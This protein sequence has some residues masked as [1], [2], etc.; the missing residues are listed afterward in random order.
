MI[1]LEF[2]DLNDI[3]VFLIAVG[4]A[5]LVIIIGDVLKRKAHLDTRF[6]R[7]IIHMFAGMATFSIPYYTH[8]WLAIFVALIFVMILGVANSNRFS[9]AFSAMARPEEIEQGLLKGPFIYS[10]SITLLVAFFTLLDLTQYFFI[11]AIPLQIMYFGDG[12]AAPIGIK[13]GKHEWIVNGSKRTFEGTLTLVVFGFLGAIFAGWFFGIFNYGLLNWNLLLFYSVIAVII[14]AILEFI[15]P[16]GYD[17]FVLPI[18]TT[19]ILFILAV[20]LH[21]LVL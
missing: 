21:L 13:Y 4:Y 1:L 14:A 2:P 7:K 10:I 6:T 15:S 19:A 20:Y 9:G 11:A 16:K 17:N 8:S 12:L 3:I 5:S 18:G